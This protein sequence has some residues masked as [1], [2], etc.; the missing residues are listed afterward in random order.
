LG[1]NWP[2]W[3]GPDG[4]AVSSEAR[5]PEKWSEEQGVRWRTE[6]P[7]E[8]SSSAIV[9][10]ERLFITSALDSGARRLT[11]CLDADSGAI[12]WT[13]EIEDDNAEVTSSLTGHAASTCATDGERVVAFFG[14]AG[15]VCYALS[16]AQVWRRDFG[17]FESELGLATSP[18]IDGKQ[19]YL[20]CDHDGDRF[21]TFDSFLT[22]LDIKTGE[23]LWRT[24][25]PG[26]FRSWSTP[27]LVPAPGGERELVINAQDELRGYDPV[28]GKL[29]WTVGGMEGWVTPSPVFAGGLIFA[30]SGRD[31]PTMAVR[32]GGRGDATRTHVAWKDEGSGPYVCSP[33]YY[34]GLLYVHDE[35]GI[36]TCREPA[37]GEILYRKR[38]GG[39]FTASGVAG[40]GKIYLG[41]EDGVWHVIKA[42]REFET[43]ARN[44]LPGLCLASPA[45]SKRRLYIRA[46]DALYCIER[47]PA[48][49]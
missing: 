28:A 32:P 38:L 17:E 11:H 37:S 24:E 39:K 21:R 34:N 22:A 35:S 30:T 12:L 3:R 9:W 31:G 1:E 2:R 42:G 48:A 47:P 10:S 36:L 8:G 25:R 5:L 49:Q 6:I 14:N 43:I 18:V 45:I 19:V 44:R 20:V 29:L 13:R 16:G 7:G 27:I 15:A 4:N 46:G 33:L 23:E 41:S 26:L 40:D